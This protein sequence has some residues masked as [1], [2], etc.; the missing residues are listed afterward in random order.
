MK[1][2]FDWL[3]DYV[4]L[5]GISPEEVAEKLTMGAFE[6]EE[7]RP[8]RGSIVGPVVVGEIL[9]ISA[10]PDPSMTKVR[11]TK[12][13]V[14][15]GEAPLEICCGAQNIE[16]GQRIPVAMLGSRVLDRKTGGALAIEPRAL[17]GVTSHGMLCSPPELGLTNGDSEGI[18]ILPHSAADRF[19]LGADIIQ[20]FHLRPDW[21]LHVEPRSNR[22]DAL[23]VVGL[24]REVAAL[25]KR[26]VKQPDWKLPA[27]EA[28]IAKLPFDVSIEDA[29]D[30]PFFTI[31]IISDLQ[32]GTSPAFMQRRLEA[33]DVR[34][35]NGIVD[36]TNYVMHEFGQPLHA[37][38][39][40]RVNGHRLDVRR[41]RQGEKLTT[42]DGKERELTGEV[43]VI[44]DGQEP[45]GVAGVMGGKDSEIADDTTMVA[46]EAAS[47]H[48]ARVRR[49]SRLLGLSSESS[50]RFERGVD[51]ASTARASDRAAYLLYKYCGKAGSTP[52][53]GRFSRAGS[54]QVKQV[55]VTCRMKELKRILDIDFD[56]AQVAQLLNP[57]GFA[58][59][60]GKE[61]LRV[62][63]PSF[64]QHDVTR[65]IDVIEEVCRLWGYDKLP[66]TMPDSTISPPRPDSIIDTVR[67]ALSGM[68]LNE[69]WLSSLTSEEDKAF[70]LFDEQAAI[71]VL[72]PLSADH[73][74]LRQ[75]LLPGLIRA[76]SYNHDH[77]QQNV[78]LF[79]VGRVYKNLGKD[80]KPEHNAFSSGT[81]VIEQQHAA[82]LLMGDNELSSWLDHTRK[83]GSRELDF[84]RA[85]GVV[86]SLLE[87]AQVPLNKI[88]FFRGEHTPDCLHPSR[89]CQV[90]FDRSGGKAPPSAQTLQV[91][92]WLGELH[93]AMRDSLKLKQTAF[94]FE[95]N[96]DALKALRKTSTF[97]EIPSTPSVMRDLTVDVV[98]AVDHAA[99]QSCISSAGGGDLQE[100]ELVS[101]YQPDGEKKSLS[102]R[103]NFQN[104]EKTLTTEEVDKSLLK[105][106]ESLTKRLAASFRA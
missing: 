100:I 7:V 64:R 27:E 19:E 21:V 76:A 66:E 8:V 65:E 28:E 56:P 74:V 105:I 86:E 72:N 22:G 94:L 37:Y 91:L 38:D 14:R 59:E 16:V 39:Y 77:G 11:V 18:L 70:G 3:S 40:T 23:S 69:A 32:A 47:F 95:L 103:L 41:A 13:R 33:I 79:E 46:L 10:H 57:L 53:I 60:A 1:L 81:G 75:S 106:R 92:G 12:T 90:A 93:P 54:D 4:D 89:S 49:A 73:Q 67:D 99:V 5:T 26:P 15:E 25:L 84:Y 82:A 45:V 58:S 2:S 102:F 36:I 34:T 50:L 6:V 35:V 98:D 88:R 63:V 24:A 52:R 31:R 30:C 104:S 9:E 62:Q 44:A 97:K 87:R 29:G 48:P 80:A 71:R 96:V 42:L 85:K 78:W 20:L 55:V 101:I 17:R 51:P 83:E 61:E 43:L 68:G